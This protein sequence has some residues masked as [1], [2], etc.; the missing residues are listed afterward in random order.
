MA[1][2]EHTDAPEAAAWTVR[3]QG[4]AVVLV[5]PGG[6]ARF[7]TPEEALKLADRLVS[8]ADVATNG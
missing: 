5:G 6:I 7:M 3:T 1:E 8:A 4:R 2:P